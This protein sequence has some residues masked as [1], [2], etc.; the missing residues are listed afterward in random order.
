ME[1]QG[2]AGLLTT[3]FWLGI[4]LNMTE[5]YHNLIPPWDKKG[6]IIFTEPFGLK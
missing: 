5:T 3:I 1:P 6:N 4:F 2:K